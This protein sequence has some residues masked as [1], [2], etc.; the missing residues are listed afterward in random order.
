MEIISQSA[1]RRRQ[2]APF[3][4]G[5]LEEI[6]SELRVPLCEEPYQVRGAKVYRL[7]VRSAELG[8]E[9]K[10][11]LWPSLARVDVYAGSVSI[12]FKDVSD[13]EILPGIEVLF[14]RAGG[15]HLFVTA[16]G[17]VATV[18]GRTSVEGKP[19]SA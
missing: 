16:A 2:R 8:I 19:A 14:H 1:R 9:V 11:V 12:V 15:G 3:D 10:I 13:V 7:Q 17:G 4:A 5:C 18:S 6:A